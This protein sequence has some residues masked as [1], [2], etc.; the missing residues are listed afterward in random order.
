MENI[1]KENEEF[2]VRTADSICVNESKLEHKW[3]HNIKYYHPTTS[4]CEYD[5]TCVSRSNARATAK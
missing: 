4:S 5:A 1:N 2:E 3:Y